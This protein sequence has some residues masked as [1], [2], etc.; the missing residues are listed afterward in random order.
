MTLNWGGIP[1]GP[2]EYYISDYEPQSKVLGKI[3]E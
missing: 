1:N 2:F 3:F